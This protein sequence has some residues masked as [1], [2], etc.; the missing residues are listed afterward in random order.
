M[1]YSIF[2]GHFM[3]PEAFR[4]CEFIEALTLAEQL[5]GYLFDWWTWKRIDL[6][7]PAALKVAAGT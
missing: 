7:R 4:S 5:N 2:V 3:R 6:E 1:R